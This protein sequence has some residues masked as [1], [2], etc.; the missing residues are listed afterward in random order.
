MESSRTSP[1]HSTWLRL[2]DNP[3]DQPAAGRGK[4]ASASWSQWSTGQG[5]HQF[6]VGG[7]EACP[8]R[9]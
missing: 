5:A 8:V 6:V 1:G 4:V 2:I 7:L 9:G 3:D